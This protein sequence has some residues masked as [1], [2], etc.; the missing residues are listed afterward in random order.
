MIPDPRQIG[1]GDGDGP[2]IP[3]K[4][5]I[6][7]GDDP[8]DPQAR[9]EQAALNAKFMGRRISQCPASLI[10]I[11]RGRTVRRRPTDSLRF[12]FRML[13]MLG[14]RS[15]FN[16]TPIDV[17]SGN[18]G[19]TPSLNLRQ[20]SWVSASHRDKAQDAFIYVSNRDRQGRI[21]SY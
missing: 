10:D 9:A 11:T 13:M 3:G 6:G 12:R 17:Y 5:G 16:A 2:P 14:A 4:L 18:D 8:R 15:M 21:L 7:G 20:L 19:A 1:D